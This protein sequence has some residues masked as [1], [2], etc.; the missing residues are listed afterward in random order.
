MFKE[1][2][3][4]QFRTILSVFR[5]EPPVNVPLPNYWERAAPESDLWISIRQVPHPPTSLQVPENAQQKE[6][7]SLH[8]IS[9]LRRTMELCEA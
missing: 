5:S 7:A 3:T 9:A 4:L 1:D 6:V 2:C 8:P